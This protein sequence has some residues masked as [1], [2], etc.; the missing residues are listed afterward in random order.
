MAS[1]AVAGGPASEPAGSGSGCSRGR[2]SRQLHTDTQHAG[3]WRLEAVAEGAAGVGD[4]RGGL[5]T[6]STTVRDNK[7]GVHRRVRIGGPDA[8]DANAG[9]RGG[10]RAR[11]SAS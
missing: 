7:E 1:T 3:E 9:E 6:E 10:K 4:R 8:A 2:R 11:A 5:Y